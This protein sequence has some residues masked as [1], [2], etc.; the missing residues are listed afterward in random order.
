MLDL[1]LLLCFVVS[2]GSA[3]GKLVEGAVSTTPG[4]D[5]NSSGGT[6][7]FEEVDGVLQDPV[8]LVE[9]VDAVDSFRRS[10]WCLELLP[11]P[12]LLVVDLSS[13]SLPPPL[14]LLLM[15]TL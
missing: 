11:E 15:T 7:V 8:E 4:F 1:L 13:F 9:P 6:M 2:L 14:L 12:L 10:L 5:S 3:A